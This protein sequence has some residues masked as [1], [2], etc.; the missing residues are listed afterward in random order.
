MII[1]LLWVRSDDDGLNSKQFASTSL[2]QYSPLIHSLAF[3]RLN[4]WLLPLFIS[5]Q[6]TFER[7]IEWQPVTWCCVMFSGKHDSWFFPETPVSTKIQT[8]L[9]KEG[10][11]GELIVSNIMNQCMGSDQTRKE[12]TKRC[13]H[14][15]RS[16]NETNT[17]KKEWNP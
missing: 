4:A 8:K 10:S 16:E 14:H 17:E 6:H 5:W 13:H 11:Q 12:P 15:Y 1:K 7:K 2:T 3:H 9:K